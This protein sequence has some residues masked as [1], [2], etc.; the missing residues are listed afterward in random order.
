MTIRPSGIIFVNND[1]TANV[2]AMLVKQLHISEV[3]SG[4]DFDTRMAADPDY[5]DVVRKLDL[6]ILV[7]R[8]FEGL[9]DRTNADIVVFISHGLASVLESKFG[10]PGDTFPVASTTWSKLGVR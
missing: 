6:R 9:D 4:D 10:P 7:V 1:L 2:Q 3:L 5:T 8:T